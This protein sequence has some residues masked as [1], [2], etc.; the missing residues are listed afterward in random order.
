MAHLDDLGLTWGLD[1]DVL[2]LKHSQHSPVAD[3]ESDWAAETVGVSDYEIAVDASLA[4][5][6][7]VNCDSSDIST[8]D[9]E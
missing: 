4:S 8:P 6:R 2:L 5:L 7:T 1:V 3:G 9:T